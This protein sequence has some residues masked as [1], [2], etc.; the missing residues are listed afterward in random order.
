MCFDQFSWLAT[1]M[2]LK[3]M[4]RMEEMYCPENV[5]KI[6]YRKYPC[7]D[8]LAS[9]S[10]SFLWNFIITEGK[11]I[12]N[13]FTGTGTYLQAKT[14][15]TLTKMCFDQFSWLPTKCCWRRWRKCIAPKM[16]EKYGSE[17]IPALTSY[18]PN[19]PLSFL[20]GFITTWGTDANSLCNN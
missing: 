6:W 16:S 17:N 2:L 20:G 18:R 4:K 15:N 1:K 13:E 19:H 7:I 10:P 11:K 12:G 5:R 8:Q 3:K 9:H 14:K